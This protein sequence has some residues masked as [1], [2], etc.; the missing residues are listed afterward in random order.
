MMRLAEKR[1]VPTSRAASEVSSSVDAC[2]FFSF[3]HPED[4]LD[5]DDRA[6]GHFSD[7][8]GQ[9][10]DGHHGERYSEEIH[11]TKAMRIEMG[12]VK[13]AIKAVL[14]S[15]MKKSMTRMMSTAPFEDGYLDVLQG[16]E[17]ENGLVV[18]GLDIDVIGKILCDLRQGL[19]DV[20][21]GGQGYLRRTAFR[22]SHRRLPRRCDYPLLS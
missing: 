8:D 4:V 22:R 20:G 16:F 15:H 21:D 19:L 9:S 18:K 11:E 10:A 3:K 14:K 13:E 12:I 17:N 2:P 5:H 6:V 1:Y 7:A